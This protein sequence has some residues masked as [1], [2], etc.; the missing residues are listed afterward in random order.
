MKIKHILISL[1]ILLSNLNCKKANE[2]SESTLILNDTLEIKCKE[3]LYNYEENISVYLDSVLNDS[4]CPKD[5][6]CKWA[7]NAEL[8][9]IFSNN[10][11]NTNFVLDTYAGNRFINDT[12]IDGYNIKLLELFPY[13]Y[14]DSVIEQK[15]YRANILIRKEAP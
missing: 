12:I 7:G 9:F 13:V 14:V 5:A 2:K 6:M 15:D 4:R 10:I 11:K 8:G 3:K 1:A